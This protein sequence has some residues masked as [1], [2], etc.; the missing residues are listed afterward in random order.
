MAAPQ[1]RLEVS[2]NLAGFRTEIQKL[3]NIAQSEF[4][5]K[6]NVKFNRRTLDTE[7]NNLQAAIKR[8]VYRVE[9][10][11]N[12]ETL[13]N[14]IR[15]LK[16]ELASLESQYPRMNTLK[17][18]ITSAKRSVRITSKKVRCSSTP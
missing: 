5:P 14:Q 3:T 16:K 4:A 9:I 1:L 10:G 8:R 2:L 11:G 6:I 18:F 15:D 13:P 12:I 17:M 7:L